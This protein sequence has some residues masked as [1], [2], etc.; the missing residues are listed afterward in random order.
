VA[1]IDRLGW[2]PAL[3]LHLAAFAAIAGLTVALERRRHGSVRTG[4]RG[5]SRRGSR[6]GARRRS[7]PQA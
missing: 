2:A 3:A 6:C 1:L 7:P 5:A 4:D